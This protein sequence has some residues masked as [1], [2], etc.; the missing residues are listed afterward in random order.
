MP[1]ETER[2]F[3]VDFDGLRAL[4]IDAPRRAIDQF[5]LLSSKECAVRIRKASDKPHAVVTFKTGGGGMSVHE[6][7]FEVDASYY[8]RHRAERDGNVV[9][10]VRYDVVHGGRT[11]EI[12]VFGGALAGLVVAELECPDAADVTDIP[13]WATK[14][15]TFDARYKNALLARRGL[16]EED[17]G[18]LVIKFFETLLQPEDERNDPQ[19]L[20]DGSALGTS[21]VVSPSHEADDMSARRARYLE[22]LAEMDADLI[23]IGDVADEESRKLALEASQTGAVEWR[24]EEQ[25]TYNRTVLAVLSSPL[26]CDEENAVRPFPPVV[27]EE[28][29]AELLQQLRLHANPEEE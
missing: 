17:G 2:K 21:S 13:D 12:D 28:D 18:R 27:S 8:D 20:G 5:Y 26:P 19:D 4:L 3:L 16:P 9:S 10:K 6:F 14:E 11:W 23:M 24:C 7:E 25:E 15:V 1:I 22:K 29:E